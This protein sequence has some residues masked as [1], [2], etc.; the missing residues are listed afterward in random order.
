MKKLSALFL[1]C[2]FALSGCSSQKKAGNE[3]DYTFNSEDFFHIDGV[4]ATEDLTAALIANLVGYNNDFFV[5]SDAGYSSTIHHN[6]TAA[7][8]KNLIDGNAKAILIPTPSAEE[9]AYAKNSNIE[10]ECVKIASD[11]L[12]F[13]GSKENAAEGF[14]VPQAKDIFSG[15]IN[16]W[17][18]VGGDDNAIG[19][20]IFSENSFSHLQFLQFIG[21]VEVA[22]GAPAPTITTNLPESN[23]L[24]Y[25]S[26]AFVDSVSD[27][28]TQTTYFAPVDA[29]GYSTYHY[30]AK[31]ALPSLKCFSL[32][33]VS[34]NAASINDGT[35]PQ[36]IEYFIYI[37]KDAPEGSFEKVLFQYLTTNGGQKIIE[38]AGYVG[39]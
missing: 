31:Q 26:N 12:V 6:G 13:V 17:S 30:F 1:I 32:N 18:E 16:K 35:Y 33:G 15:R 34:P 14:T 20:V 38:S 4:S 25:F 37:K 24:S 8:I 39:L 3:V 2:I 27:G 29:I 10:L 5:A 23:F 36:T 9:M 22:T 7:A 11:A 21:G 19:R 28:G